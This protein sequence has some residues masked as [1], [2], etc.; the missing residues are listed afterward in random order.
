[1]QIDPCLILSGLCQVR[2][3]TAAALAPPPLPLSVTAI[4]KP[5]AMKKNWCV[6]LVLLLFAVG[7]VAQPSLQTLVTNQLSEPYG[8]AVDQ[9][10]NFYVTDSVNNRVA[11]Y[12]SGGILTNLAGVFGEAGSN[13]GLG[14]FA[15]FSSPQG[16][17]FARGGLVVADSGNHRIRFVTLGGT[18]STLA[19]STAG[20]ADGAGT[21]AQFNS[22]AGLAADSAGNIYVAD[23]LNN[24]VRKIDP[25][26]NVSTVAIGFS[27]PTSVTV[28][29]ANNL[30]YVAD[31]GTHSIK[32][33]QSDGTVSLYAGSGTSYGS[34][35]KDSLIA[36]NATFNAPRGVLWAGAKTGLLVSDTGN[37][38]V[39]RVYSNTNYNTL[40]VE[41]YLNSTNLVSPVGMSMDSLGN[42]PLVDLG[43]GSLLYIQLTKPQ[44][45]VSN[46]VIGIVVMTTNSFGDIVTQLNPV[47]N[48]TFNNDV[49][50]AILGEE[51]TETFYTLD[52]NANFPDDLTSRATATAYSNGLLQWTNSIVTPSLDGSNVLVRAIG[53]QDGRHPSDIISARF[54]FKAANPV[55]NGKNPGNFT[56]SDDTDGAELWYT[57]DGTAPTNA[58]PS[59]LY[60]TAAQLNIVN[61][62]N[63]VLFKVR[64]F[65]QGY[66]PSAEV[67]KTFLF[68]DL[69]TSAIGIPRDF[70]AG[71]GSTIVVPIEVRVAGADAIKSLQFRVEVTPNDGAPAL[72]APLSNLSIPACPG[73]PDLIFVQPP[74]TNTAYPPIA[75]PYTTNSTSGIAVAYI[76]TAG[77]GSGLHLSGSATAALLS[78]PIPPTA[79]VGQSYRIS[80]LFP[81]GTSDAYSMPVPMNTLS[82]RTITVTNISYVVGDNA[83]AVWYNA[84]DFGNGNLN[85]NDV[86]MAFKVSIGLVCV[87]PFTDL[88]DSMDVFPPDSAN[89]VGGDGEVR[90][91]DWNHLLFR[92]L[93]LEP[94]NWQRSW[95]A[96]GVRVPATATLN[97]APDAPGLS[98]T[99]AGPGAVWVR[100]ASVSATSVEYGTPGQMAKVPV[101]A[102]VQNGSTLSGLQFAAKV[103]PYAGAPDINSTVQFVPAPGIPTGRTTDGLAPNQAA[104]AWQLGAF[105]PSL[106]GNVLLGTIQFTIPA[107]AQ[108]GHFYRVRFNNADGAPDANTQ[109]DFES[110]SAGVWVNSAATAPQDTISDEWKIKF[111]GSV[112]SPLADPNADPD[113]DGSPNW[114][115][116]LAGTDPT[117]PDSH[118]HLTPPAE[119]VSQGKKQI[120]MDWL[121]APGKSYVIETTTDLSSGQWT[122]ISSSISGDGYAKEFA[123]PNVLK[124]TQYYRIHLQ[125]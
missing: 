82:D 51:G 85:N 61:G 73:T 108:T 113:H 88:F 49:E 96:G 125:N 26:N 103:V 75:M 64:A 57:T 32:V 40:A 69:E 44:P 54:Q 118:L 124:H 8:V 5:K 58:A 34:G 6:L 98:L 33:I 46:P 105:N 120:V 97:S 94:G 29:N 89:T 91:L 72:V 24:M 18:V 77:P 90:F 119:K 1:M 16:I 38:R 60:L 107:T 116:Y 92:S 12:T 55:I 39:R 22:P 11:M 41:T 36:T 111:F 23:L 95:S 28:D 122:P 37:H 106:Q 59:R 78:V 112:D 80:V 48:S 74:T 86:N 27:R 10:N 81:S 79:Q 35:S 110:F 121:S 117:N 109:Y 62:T 123:D 47:V 84:G 25:A 21:A 17:V 65:K 20:F 9:N 63:N 13:D 3:A 102:K 76:D 7:A 100:E 104:Y 114:Q 31:T 19:G 50:V 53:M 101:Y 30:I 4:T 56:L 52:P 99:P 43:A 42:F 71:I 66:T 87:Y 115:E 93:R 45:P 2:R 68:T 70:N 83:S 15:H 14:P 67:S